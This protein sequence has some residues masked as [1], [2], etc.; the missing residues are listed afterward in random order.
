MPY[1]TTCDNF[2]SPAEEPTGPIY[3]IAGIV[4][5]GG[6]GYTQIPYLNGNRADTKQAGENGETVVYVTDDKGTYHEFE[7]AERYL[8]FR[9]QQIGRQE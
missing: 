3:A 7:S 1:W 4:K 9:D 6:I 5:E 2:G 8:E